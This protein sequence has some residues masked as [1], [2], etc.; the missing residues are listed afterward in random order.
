MPHALRRA[1]FFLTAT[2]LA[3][4][5]AADGP[6]VARV[7]PVTETHYGTTVVDRY[8]WM[9]NLEAPETR[10]WFEGQA[11]YAKK[12]LESLPLR[13][14]LL[15]RL[16]DVS[17]ASV[18]VRNVFPC[19]EMHWF[20]ERQAPG[21][22]EARLYQRVGIDAAER[23]VIDPSAFNADGQRYSLSTWKPSPDCKKVA[24]TVAAGGSEES[25]LRVR[26]VASGEDGPE[27]INR[28]RFGGLS[29]MPDGSLLY[30]RSPEVTPGMAES[31]HYQQL[32]TYRHRLGDDPARDRPVF[33]YGLN[34]DI[35]DGL[36]LIWA[37]EVPEGSPMAVAIAAT[38]VTQASDFY[39]A[40]LAD[41]EKSP[42]P[43]RRIASEA[44]QVSSVAIHGDN[45]YLLSFKDAPRSRVLRRSLSDP[46]AEPSV[47]VPSSQA[48]VTSMVAQP[49]ALYVQVMDA[50][51]YS[52]LR[53]DHASGAST[54]VP[55]P[56]PGAALLQGQQAQR[57]GIHLAMDS[58]TR[59]RAH[60]T[61]QPGQ[62]VPRPTGLMPPQSVKIE[63]Y[64]FTNA[65]ARSH[66]GVMVPLV[67]IHKQGI[68]RDGSHPVL[69]KGY[70]AYG[71]EYTSPVFDVSSLPWLEHGGIMVWTGVRGGG[72]YGEE[73]H[74]GGFQQT[75]PNTWK[76]FIACAEYLVAQGYT[77]PSRIGIESASAGGILVG[78]AIA[79]RPD[80]FGAAVSRVGIADMLRFETTANGVGNVPQFGSIKTEAG[81]RALLAM[82]AYRKLREGV[83]YPAVLLTA[84]YNDKRVDPWNAGKLAARLQATTSSGKPVLLRVDFDA[85]HGLGS[86]QDQQNQ[87]TADV[88]A[89]L[90]QQLGDH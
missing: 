25:E 58:W 75:K 64:E 13:A 4:A 8:R 26:E 59:S 85:G 90:F 30:I 62:T 41:L 18:R 3:I 11:A 48:V 72:E 52:I 12:E 78:N 27:R 39:V 73:W 31:A 87:T 61:W 5:H 47:V 77:K 66:D 15:A 54:T 46:T 88:Y 56:Y 19:G 67:I 28:T 76:D 23:L 37:V 69:M 80:L 42:V 65:Q 20:Y 33:G 50:G 9:E 45:L 82:D 2:M 21:E 38:G 49:D 1:A 14:A 68:A 51:N 57:P 29:W 53:H 35:P 36:D 7:D 84:G 43:W 81:F 74:Q 83:A 16:T 34:P 86:T 70:G 24:Y 10:A 17:S 63:G 40:P 32:R 79:E 55:V 60:F 6:P 44:D 89:F 71:V 22:Q